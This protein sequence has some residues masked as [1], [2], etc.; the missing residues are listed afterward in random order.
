MD[1]FT[2]DESMGLHDVRHDAYAATSRLQE[3]ARNLTNEQL[4]EWLVAHRYDSDV[5]LS[6]RT[7][8]RVRKRVYE[9]E[10]H[11]RGRTL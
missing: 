2:P 6:R 3:R 8:T 4:R 5:S 1:R 7:A 9:Q 11:R 10:F